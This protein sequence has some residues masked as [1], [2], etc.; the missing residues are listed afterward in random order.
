M[1]YS[2]QAQS[3]ANQEAS[4]SFKETS[5]AFGITPETADSLP[6]PAELFLGAFAACVLK[7]VERFSAFMKFTYT[8]A[9][10]EVSATRLEKPPRLDEIHYTLR[11]FSNDEKLNGALLKK[12]LE[13]FGTIYNTVKL[14]CS[15][16]GEII[17]ANDKWVLFVL[18]PIWI[19]FF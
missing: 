8:K 6:G 12:N 14:S 1:N 9:E 16:V 15:I 10:I 11:I 5:T 2:I 17:V 19:W 7:N 3:T 13:K 4:I 18:H